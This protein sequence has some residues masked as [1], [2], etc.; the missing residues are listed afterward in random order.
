MD[1]KVFVITI[2]FI[3]YACSFMESL[4]SNQITDKIYQRMLRYEHHQENYRKSLLNNITPYGLQLKKNAQ[5]ETISEDFSKKWQNVLYDAERRLVQLLLAE[6]ELA[7]N[8]MNRDLNEIINSTNPE[9]PEELKNE[10]INRNLTLKVTLNERRVKK[11]RKFKR[12]K[13]VIK[14]P[15][16]TSK[17]SDYV[18]IALRRSMMK[19]V[20]DNRK[21]REKIL[22]QHVVNRNNIYSITD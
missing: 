3:P 20:T 10:I 14:S 12:K 21:H 17:V 19:N 15:R 2:I 5:I 9:N 1:W 13:R 22:K 6:S 8:Q 18:E 16:R 4:M 11:W 7:Y